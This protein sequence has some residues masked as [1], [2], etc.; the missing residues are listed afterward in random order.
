VTRVGE[1]GEVK[2]GDFVGVLGSLGLVLFAWP[3]FRTSRLA[4]SGMGPLISL[5]G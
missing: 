4:D 5:A 1:G 3:L 2:V